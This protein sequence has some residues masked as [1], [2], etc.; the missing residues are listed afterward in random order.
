MALMAEVA[1]DENDYEENRCLQL[2][3]SIPQE[4]RTKRKD[5]LSFGRGI[6]STADAVFHP[7]GDTYNAIQRAG[8]QA[9]GLGA[10]P[11]LNGWT[12]K[13]EEDVP[14]FKREA[15]VGFNREPTYFSGQAGVSAKRCRSD[16]LIGQ[17]AQPE[18]VPSPAARLE[19]RS[20]QGLFT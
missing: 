3:I 17:A 12:P 14:E 10:Q 1:R 8:L 19:R 9:P 15:T 16:N 20:R 4:L 6:F 2:G 7:I 11:V 13:E 5:T 18:R